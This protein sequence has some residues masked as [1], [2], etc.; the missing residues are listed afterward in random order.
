MCRPRPVTALTMP[1]AR[2]ALRHQRVDQRRLADAAVAD[3]HAGAARR[4]RSRSSRQVA[5]ALGHDPR[6]AERAVGRE[7]GLRVGEVGLGEAQQRPHPGVVRRHQRAVDQPRP[8]LGVG[9][10]GDDDQL[11]G[12]GDDHPLD[13]VVVVGGTAQHGG[14]LVDLDDPGQAAV[15]ARDVADDAD[16]VADDHALA[17]QRPGLHRRHGAR[18]RPAACSGRGRRSRR[19]RRRRRRR[20]AAPWCAAGCAVA[21]ARSARGRARSSD[22]SYGRR[23]ARSARSPGSTAAPAQKPAKSGKVLAVVATSSTSTP[24]T[25]APTM[26]PAWAIRWSA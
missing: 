26:T 12:V 2:S 3:Q 1:I 25:A 9:Q 4:A 19:P 8:R 17:A 13:R 16:P 18:R 11:V 10:R 23:L 15:G 5:A 7:Q 22:R 6:H 21:A 24:S 14:A 20:R